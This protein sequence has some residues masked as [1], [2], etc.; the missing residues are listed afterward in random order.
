[1]DL[2]LNDIQEMLVDENQDQELSECF[3]GSTFVL[4]GEFESMS[5]T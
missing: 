4:T 1:M 3:L 5:R 2:D